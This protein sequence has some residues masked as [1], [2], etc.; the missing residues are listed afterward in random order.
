[1]RCCLGLW[2]SESGRGLE[3]GARGDR[4]TG[5]GCSAGVG[6][7][8]GGDVARGLGLGRPLGLRFLGPG[9][10]HLPEI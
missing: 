7:G 6:R 3:I 10:Q 9:P 5:R 2:G 4:G 8:V 1:M